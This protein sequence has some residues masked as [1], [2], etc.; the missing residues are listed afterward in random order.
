MV[1]GMD[2][3]VKTTWSMDLTEKDAIVWNVESEL[4]DKVCWLC[5][6]RGMEDVQWYALQCL[7]VVICPE[8]ER[9]CFERLSVSRN[10]IENGA[11][12][13]VFCKL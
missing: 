13:L 4:C 10:G 1:A 2:L 7:S 11:T 5:C 8:V 12:L 6:W 9:A 3:Q